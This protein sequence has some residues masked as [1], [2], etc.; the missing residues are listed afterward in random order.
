[1]PSDIQYVGGLPVEGPVLDP[2]A[3]RE[4][5]KL[6]EL[7]LS[8]YRQEGSICSHRVCEAVSAYEDYAR[9]HVAG[10]SADE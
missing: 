6:T 4:R 3:E 5:D 10:V 2:L 7:V 8:A 1:M 9:F